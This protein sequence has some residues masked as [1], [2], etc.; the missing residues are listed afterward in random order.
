MRLSLHV[1]RDKVKGNLIQ[2]I[3]ST[4]KDASGQYMYLITCLEV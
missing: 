1:A 3:R 2:K 4:A